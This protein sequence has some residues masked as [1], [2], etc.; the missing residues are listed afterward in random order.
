MPGWVTIPLGEMYNPVFFIGTEYAIHG[1]T[2]VPL[3]PASRGCVRIPMNTAGFFHRWR[4]AGE[5]RAQCQRSRARRILAAPPR[6]CAAKLVKPASIGSALVSKVDTAAVGM[7]ALRWRTML[8]RYLLRA[9][10]PPPPA[11]TIDAAFVLSQP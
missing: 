10:A 4:Y 9:H 7:A 1:A 2:D 8:Q 11:S 6:L 5:R 3:R